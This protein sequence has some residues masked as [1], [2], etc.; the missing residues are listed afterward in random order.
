MIFVTKYLVDV[1]RIIIDNKHFL[2]C[3]ILF[4]NV[5]NKEFIVRRN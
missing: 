4:E 5:F 3:N 1:D 2:F